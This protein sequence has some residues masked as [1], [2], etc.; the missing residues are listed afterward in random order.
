VARKDE[1]DASKMEVAVEN[2]AIG[3]ISGGW[4]GSL[5]IKIPTL[6]RKTRQEW[7]PCLIFANCY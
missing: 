2:W 1:K 5:T 7:A 4:R 3:G 6:S